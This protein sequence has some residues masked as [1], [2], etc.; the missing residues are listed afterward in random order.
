ME[1]SQSY[2]R[3]KAS[4]SSSLC[5]GNVRCTPAS[6]NSTFCDKTFNFS[7]ITPLNVHHTLH[8]H[9]KWEEIH[10]VH[11]T[12]RAERLTEAA[13]LIREGVS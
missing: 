3:A 11:T 1:L 2:T 12:D 10:T 4:T 7:I 13:A 8:A 9:R 5:V 6:G